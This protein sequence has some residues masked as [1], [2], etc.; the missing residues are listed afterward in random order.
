MDRIFTGSYPDHQNIIEP[1]D[2]YWFQLLKCGVDVFL[3]S[4]HGVNSQ[5]MIKS[6]MIT[7]MH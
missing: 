7:T 2:I 4:I 6:N 1:S 3:T 5:L